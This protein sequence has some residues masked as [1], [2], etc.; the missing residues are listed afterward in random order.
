VL[1]TS[2]EV[3]VYFVPAA[4]TIVEQL[5]PFMSQRS[6]K[7]SKSVGLLSQLSRWPVGTAPSNAST[8]DHLR[9]TSGQPGADGFAW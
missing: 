7:S 9:D 5:P 8:S 4:P 1:P 6:Q 2:A 3:S